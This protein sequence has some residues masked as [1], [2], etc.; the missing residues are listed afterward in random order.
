MQWA[1]P[2]KTDKNPPR[3]FF[4]G[5]TV[6]YRV[7][8]GIRRELLAEL[9]E[10]VSDELDLGS[11]DDLNGGLTGTDN[12]SSAGG[13]DDLLVNQQ[14]VLDF[15]SQTGN[16]VVDGGDVALAADAF[17][18]VLSHLGE[19]VVGQLDVQLALGVALTTGGLEV[20]L[21]DGKT[22]DNVE[23]H[24]GSDAHGNDDPVVVGSGQSST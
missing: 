2:G 5:G 12:A 21:G 23:D 11:D 3:N 10:L 14:T 13:L 18:D 8:R 15:Q 24:E 9:L 22:E 19:V 7:G 16:A 1:K 6:C 20:E 17:Q 4:R